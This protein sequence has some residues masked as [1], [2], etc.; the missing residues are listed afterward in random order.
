MTHSPHR[1]PGVSY[2][3]ALRASVLAG[4]ALLLAGVVGLALLGPAGGRTG[5]QDQAAPLDPDDARLVAEGQAIYARACAVCH[6]A[7]LEGHPSWQPGTSGGLAPP[8]DASGPVPRRSDAELFALT[9]EGT[10]GG[11]PAF[12][13][14]LS[15][16]EIRAVLSYVK[17]SWT[18]LTEGGA[19]GAESR[20]AGGPGSGGS[21][22]SGEPGS[23]EPWSGGPEGR[24][25]GERRAGGP[26]GR[27]AESRA[28][29]ER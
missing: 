13:G 5:G 22:G 20:R 17:R 14:T 27:G 4:V 6:G 28:N 9:K 12:G 21:G 11:M 25:A 29:A 7:R 3:R 10:G 15:D 8:L 16:S 26:E 18:S 19:E 1:R 24:R 2:A 23:G